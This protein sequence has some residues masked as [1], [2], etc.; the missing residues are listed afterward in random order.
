M[1]FKFLYKVPS[2]TLKKNLTNLLYLSQKCLLSA[3]NKLKEVVE[4]GDKR[5]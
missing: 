2:E 3:W 1:D 5:I 4:Q